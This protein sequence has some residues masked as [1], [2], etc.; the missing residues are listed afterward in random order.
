MWATKPFAER[1]PFEAAIGGSFDLAVHE[2]VRMQ[3]TLHA[4]LQRNMAG[5]AV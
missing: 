4:R 2:A 3:S 1:Q 5:S